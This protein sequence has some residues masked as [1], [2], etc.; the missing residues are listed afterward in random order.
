MTEKD[1]IIVKSRKQG[2]A[3]ISVVRNSEPNADIFH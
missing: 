2:S 1:F 3:G